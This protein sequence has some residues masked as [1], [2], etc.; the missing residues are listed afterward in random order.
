MFKKIT[1]RINFLTTVCFLYVLSYFLSPKETLGCFQN[2]LMDFLRVLPILLVVFF[3]MFLSY[4]FLKPSIIKKHLGEDSGVRGWIFASLAS[5]FMAAPI[6][7]LFP[8]LKE[9][10]SQGMKNSL[11]AVFLNNRNVQP[12]FLPVLVFYF[13]LPFTIVFSILILCYALLSGFLV[14]Q[15]V[16]D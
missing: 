16:K 1:I 10:K 9:L 15:F 2:F 12:A 4:M 13:G 7:L 6:Y 3:V 11:I 14:G 8:L 5:I